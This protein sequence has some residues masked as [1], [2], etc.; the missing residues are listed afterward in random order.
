LD[1]YALGLQSGDL[2]PDEAMGRTRVLIDKIS[3]PQALGAISDD[4]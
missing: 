2:T 1:F 4:F 3:D